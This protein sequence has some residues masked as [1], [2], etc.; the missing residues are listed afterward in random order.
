M[1]EIHAHVLPGLDDGAADLAEAQALVAEYGRQGVT[2]IICTSHLLPGNMSGPAGVDYLRRYDVQFTGLRDLFVGCERPVRLHRGLELVLVPDLL[3]RLRHLDRSASPLSLAGSAYLLVEL[4]HWLAG[5]LGSL[6]QLLFN[7]Q[8]LGFTP[9]LAHPERIVDFAAVWPTLRQWVGQERVLLQVNA[10]AIVLP[11]N[12]QTDQAG[13]FQ[14]RHGAADQMIRAGMV[15]F[16]ASD[17]H[18]MTSR[19]P[20]HR[21]AWTVLAETYGE[22]VARVL[23]LDNPAAVLADGPVQSVCPEQTG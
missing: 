10:S 18:H 16:A 5:G 19:P 7:L 12:A 20:R 4:P 1:I 6:E 21:E 3:S 17:A 9:I 23:L 14:R 2:D 22:A 11:E 13:R 8:L 15:H